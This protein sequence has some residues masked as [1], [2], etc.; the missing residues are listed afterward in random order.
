M[1]PPCCLCPPPQALDIDDLSEL[2]LQ[3]AGAIAEAGDPL[4]E[5]QHLAQDFPAVV[6][7][8]SQ[9]EAPD[10]MLPALRSLQGY[11]PPSA[12]FLLINGLVYDLRDF[13]LYELLD[14][15]RKEASVLATLF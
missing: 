6:E 7:D 9:G 14:V 10:D 11:L 3:A 8:L 4:L 1:L 15:V 5:L 13:N 12:H 2:G